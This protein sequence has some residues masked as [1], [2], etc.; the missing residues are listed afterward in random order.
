MI[1]LLTVFFGINLMWVIIKSA[2]EAAKEARNVKKDNFNAP[3]QPF[4][5]LRLPGNGKLTNEEFFNANS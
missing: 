5:V 4:D 2:V 3:L 1:D